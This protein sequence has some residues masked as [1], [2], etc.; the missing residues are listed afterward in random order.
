MGTPT[1][2]ID[3]YKQT[4]IWKHFIKVTKKS[5]EKQTLVEELVDDAIGIL[6]KISETFPTY[7]LH[8]GQHQLNILNLFEK[9]LGK[10]MKDVH[11]L[12]AAILILSAFYHD[13]G[14]VFSKE[15]KED[16][17]NE[18]YFNDFL[19]QNNRAKLNIEEDNGISDATAEWYCRWS[20]AKR[21]W[22]YLEPLDAKLEWE[23]TPLREALANVCLS[24][25]ETTDWIKE[26]TLDHN[27]WGCAD[28]K[29]CAI[30]LRLADVLDF[31]DTRTPAY[32]FQFLGLDNPTTR[33]EEISQQ[34]WQK[35]IASRGFSFD[36]W[37]E[38]HNYTIT[39]KANPTSPA[40]EQDIRNFLS[41]IERELHQCG[42]VLNFC[43]DRWKNFK[44]PNT[45]DKKNIKSKG[46]T[47]GDFKFSLD[48]EQVLSLL[49]GE[50][51][52][53]DKFVCIR[54][55]LQNAIDT[56]RH[57]KFYEQNNGNPDFEPQ[58]IDIDTWYDNEGYRWIRIDDY[59]MGMT[60]EQ[61][62]KYFLKVGNSYYNSDE[63]KVEKLRY[64]KANTDFT[65]VSRFGIGILSCFIVADIVE[66]NTR[67][68]QTDNKK[69]Y[70]IRL[71][72]KGLHNYYVLQTNK[73]LP[74]SIPNRD[75]LQKGYRKKTGTSLALRIQ[76]N[77]DL[78]SFNLSTI[79]DK[80]LFNPF[81]KINLIGK[82]EKGRYLQSINLNNLPILEYQMPSTDIKEIKE[83]LSRNSHI[84]IKKLNPE[85]R[86]TP[87]SLSRTFDHP[88]IKGLLY[89]ITLTPNIEFEEGS[90]E[91]NKDLLSLKYSQNLKNALNLEVDN[92]KYN[93]SR[94][95][96]LSDLTD[97]IELFNKSTHFKHLFHTIILS[98]NG[99]LVP[100]KDSSRIQLLDIRHTNLIILGHVEL[101][102]ILRPNLSIARNK[103][104]SIPWKLWS[105]LNFT[106]RKNIPSEYPHLK[107]ANFLN[108]FITPKIKWNYTD[109]ND[110]EYFSNKKKWPSEKI[111]SNSYYPKKGDN[112]YSLIDILDQNFHFNWIFTRKGSTRLLLQK[113]LIEL[114]S[115]YRITLCKK[116]IKGG[117]VI[118][119]KKASIKRGKNPS[120]LNK[121]NYPP[122]MFCE[123]I[124]FDGLMPEKLNEQ[125]F[126]SNHLFSKWLMNCYNY[127]DSHYQNHLYILLNNTDLAVINTTLEKLR[128]HL[129]DQYKPDPNLHLTEDDFKVDYDKIPFKDEEIGD[130]EK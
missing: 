41:Y 49:M 65:P 79:L 124:N 61:I 97:K 37:N 96:V 32:L 117:K 10:R 114:Y 4:K 78:P 105:H 72:L 126:N 122:L 35:H 84:N 7:T 44:L 76:P 86:V 34:E 29:F 2:T 51:L 20:H 92:L 22:K 31:D 33:G 30:L 77:N 91:Y 54:E 58:A 23:G 62:S 1:K 47:F 53:D 24:H 129:P 95:I 67:S 108:A 100:N 57:R 71:S 52:Y 9:L 113:K 120:V 123:Y 103:M 28:L 43:S 14:M 109:L 3:L 60:H 118:L 8:N 128:S 18:T 42:S 82:G 107:K 127:L 68:I 111:F 90:N 115:I 15:E 125:I 45:I 39:Y 121:P 73:D 17:K 81:V 21:V 50:S 87:I 66:I 12:E 70:P 102:D 80:T 40:I 75:G 94:D 88:N 89:F 93:H 55:L 101:S 59:G 64:K 130:E 11:A 83:F 74:S 48:Q 56:S 13:I 110:D 69:K 36:A 116:L 6:D 26:D 106:I 112:Y 85:I 16:L 98:H 119:Q 19:A 46:Y 27:F 25:N 104:T 63:F 5:P 99:I 38:D